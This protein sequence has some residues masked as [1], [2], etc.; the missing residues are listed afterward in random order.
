[1]TTDSWR[2]PRRRDALSYWLREMP[3][4]APRVYAAAR[5][6]T[7]SM[8]LRP[9]AALNK[10][11]SAEVDRQ[12]MSDE[13]R[14]LVTDHYAPRHQAFLNWVEENRHAFA[15]WISPGR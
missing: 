5:A 14:K 7:R 4:R 3:Q 12:K 13:A 6:V 15:G 11:L 10:A 9:G 2:L 1:M 8:G